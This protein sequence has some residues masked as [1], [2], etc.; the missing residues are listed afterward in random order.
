MKLYNTAQGAG[1][2][3]NDGNSTTTAGNTDWPYAIEYVETNGA[4]P[5]CF[6]YVN[7]VETTRVNGI[8]DGSGQCVCGYR[9]YGLN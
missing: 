1:G 2:D 8:G 3:V 9:N 4:G 7:G 5:E 6:R